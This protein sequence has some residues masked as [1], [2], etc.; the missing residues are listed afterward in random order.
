MADRISSLPDEILCHILSFV[1]TKEAAATSVL[2]KRWR[3]LWL[4]VP[5]LD[6][7]DPDLNCIIDQKPFLEFVYFTIL[8]R[9]PHQ[10]FKR[11]TLTKIA[12]DNVDLYPHMKIWLDSAAQCGIEHLHVDL[13]PRYWDVIGPR[14]NFPGSIFSCRTLVVLKLGQCNVTAFPSPVYLPSLKILHLYDVNFAESRHRLE[15]LNGCP[16]LEELETDVVSYFVYATKSND[17]FIELKTLSKLVRASFG[18]YKIPL[19][20]ACNVEFLR[21]KK[22]S[23]YG[24]GKYLL[25]VFCFVVH[26]TQI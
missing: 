10:P 7:H 17:P 24:E 12:N 20:A 9:H 16:I 4:S 18:K 11:F 14:W 6:L 3:S 22:V 26:V 21:L 19:Q 5:V 25:N 15:L 23:T 13:R 8:V 1:T 2:S